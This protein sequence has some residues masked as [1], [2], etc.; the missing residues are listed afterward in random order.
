MGTH[1]GG[2]GVALPDSRR[3]PDTNINDSITPLD[4][5]AAVQW[6][7][8]AA[9][10]SFFAGDALAAPTHWFYGGPRQIQQYYGRHGI[11][12]YT[13]PVTELPGSILNKSNL[14]GG[15]RSTPTTIPPNDTIIGHV[16]NHGKQAF[17]DPSRSIHYH[18]TLQA[19]ENTLEAQLGR[20][21]LRSLAATDGTLDVDHFRQS[22]VTFMTTP[23]S[24]N[25]TYASTC[26]RMFFA[27][28]HYK[29]RDP[30][31]CPDND[32]HNVDTVDGLV[33]PTIAAL[34]VALHPTGTATQAAS[35][36]AATVAVTRNSPLLQR[37]AQEWAAV[38]FETVRSAATTN[39][40]QSSKDDSNSY[41]PV[42][43]KTLSQTMARNLGL[44]TPKIQSSADEITACYLDSAVPA[45]LDTLLKYEPHPNK[46]SDVAVDAWSTDVWNGLLAN[47]NTGGENVHRA[48][49]LG[50]VWGAAAAAA[51][52][53][54][55]P[56]S[57]AATA[58]PL[59][60][61]LYHHDE[62]QAEIEALLQAVHG[63][64]PSAAKEE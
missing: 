12:S 62:I 37:Y 38:V 10:W 5:S 21:L 33:L 34:A 15:G 13:K 14:A 2:G 63:G 60:T 49:C 22:Y 56:S 6:I 3:L 8:A 44:R 57:L 45:M 53:P 59:A 27:N 26:H 48:S 32:K 7:V 51:V 35:S 24:H 19:G 11:A 50:A 47:A 54:P 46:K 30:M 20:V 25:D 58:S 4:N 55:R 1:G 18:A 29:K 52:G 16:I 17:W 31:D 28:W 23:G 43:L 39:S 41:S 9:L 61:G 42:S 40:Q 36:A 64:V